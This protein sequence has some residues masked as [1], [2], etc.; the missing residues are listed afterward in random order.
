MA[1]GP[2]RNKG[3]FTKGPGKQNWHPGPESQALAVLFAGG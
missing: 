3:I 1:V 2:L